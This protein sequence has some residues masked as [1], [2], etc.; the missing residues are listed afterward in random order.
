MV[1]GTEGISPQYNVKVALSEN[2]LVLKDYS[3]AI[4]TVCREAYA[5]GFSAGSVNGCLHI[6]A[7]KPEKI[8]GPEGMAVVHLFH[9]MGLGGGTCLLGDP[10]WRA[11]EMAAMRQGSGYVDLVVQNLSDTWGYRCSLGWNTIE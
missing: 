1:E 6:C 4:R 8:R 7:I 11:E 3:E 2:I 10:D 5:V 9:H